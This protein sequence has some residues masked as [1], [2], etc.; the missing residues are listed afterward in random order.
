MREHLIVYGLARMISD[1]L[2]ISD[3][4]AEVYECRRQNK[5]WD[6]SHDLEHDDVT[7]IAFLE[8]ILFWHDEGIN[9]YHQAASGCKIK[10]DYASSKCC[11]FSPTCT[12]RIAPFHYPGA[13]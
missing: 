13:A 3:R 6:K 4:S 10:A 1:C 12:A 11:S 9:Y 8:L 2:T 7:M 5:V